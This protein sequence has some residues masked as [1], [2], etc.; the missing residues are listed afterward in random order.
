MSQVP[1][2]RLLFNIRTLPENTSGFKDKNRLR[3]L[4]ID[5][6][7]QGDSGFSILQEKPG[8]QVVVGAIGKFW[9][10][11]IPFKKVAPHQFNAFS[12]PG[13]GKVAWSISVE[14]Y[15]EGSTISLELRISATDQDSWRKLRRYYRVIGIG[16]KLIRSSAMRRFKASLVEMQKPD[17]K[18]IKLEGDELLPKAKHQLTIQR[19]IEAPVSL[20]WRYL[21]QLGCDRA[22]WYS[23]DALDNGGV[24]GTEHLVAGWETRNVG[25]R[26][27]ATPQHDKF[28][29]VYDVSPETHFVIGGTTERDGKKFE[30][31][32][33]FILEP[34][35]GDATRLI[36]R[37]R[38]QTSPRWKEFLM[39][40]IIY[41]P[42]HGLMS[43]VQLDTIKRLAER[44]AAVRAYEEENVLA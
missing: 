27:D 43:R 35:G 33:A 32:W 4:G 17:I 41:P 21:M 7:T 30:M 20:V 25:D 37:A 18:N 1:W 3:G 28:F 19:V 38:M 2:I 9:R 11:N 8:Q 40:R 39:G 29:I 10:L 44:D 23:I 6:I 31:T 24:T 42:V 22:G 26:I 5:A 13:Y 15:L 12:E 36:T 14:P 34:I 16:S